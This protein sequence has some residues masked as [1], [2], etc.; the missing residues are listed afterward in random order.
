[1]DQISLS[2][3]HLSLIRTQLLKGWEDEQLAE[4][5]KMYTARC[6]L[7]TMAAHFQRTRGSISGAIFRARQKGLVDRVR[8]VAVGK[9]APA[10]V[11]P[12]PPVNPGT[13]ALANRLR[14]VPKAKRVRLRLIADQNQVTFAQ[15]KQHHCRW[16]IGDPRQ[17]D[18]RFCG[19]S[20]VAGKPYCVEHVL[21][22]GKLY[23]SGTAP[24]RS[25]RPSY[26]RR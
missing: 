3:S 6:S 7:E 19:C 21:K 18:F 14:V 25:I 13:I 2:S 12:K 17:S 22:A 23:E 9:P 11:L 5:L 15:L 20:R 16:P 26:Q 1:M 4:L 24:V 8:A 10:P